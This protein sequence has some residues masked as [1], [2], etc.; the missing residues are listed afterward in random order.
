MRRRRPS[1]KWRLSLSLSLLLTLS[2]AAALSAYVFSAGR[3]VGREWLAAGELARALLAS[4]PHQDGVPLVAPSALDQLAHIRHLRLVEAGGE[5]PVDAAI[6]AWFRRAVLPQASVQPLPL[7]V[8]LDNGTLR[9]LALLPTA[10]DEAEEIWSNLVDVVGVAVGML[11]VLNLGSWWIV[12]SQLAPLRSLTA[13]LDDVGSG[14]RAVQVDV[15]AVEEVA[16]VQERFNHMA[17][18]LQRAA[19]DNRRLMRELLRVQEA[20]RRAIAR[21]LHDEFAQQVTAID[22]NAAAALLAV[23]AD[24]GT[25]SGLAAIRAAAATLMRAVRGRLRQLRP[26]VLDEFGLV[27]ALEELC[28]HFRAQHPALA[29]RTRW[30]DEIAV[31]EEHSICLVRVLQEALTNVARHAQAGTAQVSLELLREG[32]QEGLA[33][34]IADDGR[35]LEEGAGRRRGFGLMGMRE[36]LESLGGRLELLPGGGTAGGLTLRAWLPL[37]APSV[38]AD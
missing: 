6:P 8:R 4:A 36:R 29:I 27:P 25:A 1:L 7:R 15:Q 38:A 16:Q 10:D 12:R 5:V 34:A 28:E 17:V 30:P 2:A 24:S 9:E 21:E 11:L 35:G 13:A 33:M 20:E 3:S 31:G 14:H 19:I 26:E 23:P 18:A 32:D 22:A 37:R